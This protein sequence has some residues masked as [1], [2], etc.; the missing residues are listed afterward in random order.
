MKLDFPGGSDGKESSCSAGAPGSSH[1]WGRSPLRDSS[2]PFNAHASKKHTH[3]TGPQERAG[4]QDPHSHRRD[5]CRSTWSERKPAWCRPPPGPPPSASGRP[6]PRPHHPTR[7]KHGRS[8]LGRDGGAGAQIPGLEGRGWPTPV[9]LQ[10]ESQG[11]GSLVGCR[12]WGRTE[13]DTT[14]AT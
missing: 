9:F 10:G 14:E 12:L 3:F 1:G 13:L 7:T 11:R 2:S 5:V 8:R 6:V 4:G